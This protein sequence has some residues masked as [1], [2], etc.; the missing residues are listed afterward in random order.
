MIYPLSLD[1]AL[2]GAGLVLV[3]LGLVAL[4]KVRA[5]Q[6]WLVA[7]P[8]SRAWGLGLL[9][10]AS[11]WFWIL[12]LTIDLGEFD[13]WRRI[14]LLLIPICAFL[15]GRYMDELLAPRAAGMLLLL[16]AEP[17]LESA[18][19]RPE[20][21]RLLLVTLTYAGIVFAM[22]WIGMP[23]VMRDQ[24]NWLTASERRWRV[25]ALGAIAYGSLLLLA[26][27]TLPPSSQ[28]AQPSEHSDNVSAVRKL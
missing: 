25:G 2:L 6:A 19:L 1:H 15:T 5:V 16:A 10:V 22:F 17:L 26:C 18:F 4:W 7:L 23:Y 14:F 11:L 9:A 20:H 21:T 24:I 3:L 12:I 13:N 8:R 28:A 27:L